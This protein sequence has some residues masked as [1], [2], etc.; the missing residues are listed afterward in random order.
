M[1]AGEKIGVDDIVRAA[2][3]DLVLIALIGIGFDRGDPGRADIGEVRAQR[4]RAQHRRAIGDR[5]RQRDRTFEPF[6]NFL[7][8]G[9]RRL[10][11]GMPARAGGD[12]DEPVGTLFNRLVRET[13]VDDV[14]HRDAAPI[15]HRL[16]QFL[17]RAERGDDHRHLPFLADLHVFLEPAI[18]AVDDLVDRERCRRTI[19]IVAIMRGQF[20]GDLVHPFIEL[21]RRP[22][23]ERGEAADDTRLALG[24]DQFRPRHDEHRRTDD[25]QAQAVE[26]GGDGHGLE[27]PA[28]NRSV[29]ACA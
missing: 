3:H 15:V 6:A 25:R 18:G 13:V 17:A 12:R 27:S 22:G 9:E 21:A 4:L 29:K 1:H 19:G 14:V 28:F 8:Q 24:D 23:I 7:H 10:R 16:V 11:A 2:V 26:R 5:A 20:L